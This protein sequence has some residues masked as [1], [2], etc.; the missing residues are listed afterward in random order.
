MDDKK[1]SKKDIPVV[2]RSL[3]SWILAGN[4]KLQ[5]G[6]VIL[7]SV[8]VFARVLPL[9]MQKKIIN[10]AIALRKLDLLYIYCTYYIAAV[11]LASV[12]KFII[13]ILQT[14]VSQRVLANMRK[15]LYHHLLRL[16]MS[17]FRKTQPG[18]V[19]ASLVTE[20]ATAGTFVGMAVAVP[21]IN[22]LTLLAF[23]GYLL[24]LNWILAVISMSI[25]PAV[26]F[27]IPLLQRKVNKYNRD[28]V[29][30]T[31]V[32]SNQISDTISGIHEVHGNGSFE[33]E[34]KKYD[35]IVD[36]LY[37][38]RIVWT[39]YQ[40]AVKVTN[41]FFTNLGPFL[42][43]L[44]GGYL[45][46]KGQLELGSLVAF[47]SAQEKLY[48]PWREIIEFYQTYQDGSVQYYKSMTYFDEAIEHEVRPKDRE[49]Y[50]L[51]NTIEVKNL[52]FVTQ[53][54]IRL[55]E[56]VNL[57]LKPGEHLALV[58]FSGSGK[59]T[60]AQCIGQLYKYTGGQVLIGG[61][62]VTDLTKA[63]MVL[64]IGYVPQAPFIFT[65]TFEDNLLYSCD[66]LS[67]S[68]GRSVEEARPSLDYII[69]VLQ[70]TGVFVDVLRFGLNTILSRD[71]GEVAGRIIGIRK[72]FVKDFGEELAD[73]VEFFNQE[74]FLYHS[75]VLENLT[76]G[77][78]NIESF[79]DE[80]LIKNRFFID[81]LDEADLTRPFLSLGAELSK[82]TVDILGNLPPDKLFFKQSPIQPEELDV[83]KGLVETLK[84]KKLHQLEAADRERLL[85]LAL[86]FI[87]GRHKMVGLPALLEQLILEGRSLFRDRIQKKKPEAYTFFDMEKYINSQTILNNILFGKTKTAKADAQDR[88]NQSIIQLLIEEDF[89]EKIVEIGMKF[90]VGS[91]GDNLSGGQRQKLAIAR[92]F[93]KEPPILILDEATSALDNKSQTR[94]QNQLSTKWKGHSTL[95]AVIHRLDIAKFYDKV[96][97]MKAGK[98]MEFGPYNELIEKKGM[99]YELVHGKR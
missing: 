55:L 92:A 99:L 94:V 48:D 25:Y 78:A 19:V 17:F 23:A 70:Q 56:G 57:S 69:G 32:M 50:K 66:A 63:D 38:I 60:L 83:Y 28:R 18:L 42:I 2:K 37:R 96:A 98:I 88:I 58:G 9:E 80:F 12:L 75:S 84:K 20:L 76:F 59:S 61:R 40:Q 95:I 24:Y 68:D 87:P 26:I 31:R 74:S 81:F 85:E 89:L 1:S 15:D 8:T 79:E 13:S 77:T 54:G 33:I 35:S 72:D 4:V 51:D 71:D 41:N 39:L 34:H 22:V 73:Y 29:D 36:K 7:V 67:E 82:Q 14:M 43:F 64:N 90:Q 6:I 5:V 44:L 53:E 45:A 65:G 49:L 16:P 21:L 97:V 10:D 62:E 46:M 86:R 91:K 30:V 93:L 3:F 47:L 11:I 52:S 27:L